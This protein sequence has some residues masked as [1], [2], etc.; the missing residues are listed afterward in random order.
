MT[1]TLWKSLCHV[2]LDDIWLVGWQ[3][4]EPPPPSGV[5]TYNGPLPPQVTTSASSAPPCSTLPAFPQVTAR[6]AATQEKLVKI[7][8]GVSTAP[9]THRDVKLT[10]EWYEANEAPPHVLHNEGLIQ[11][12]DEISGTTHEWREA[13]KHTNRKYIWWRQGMCCRWEGCSTVRLS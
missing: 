10:G 13:F 8:G 3:L 7:S 6:T 12:L 1:R 5:T 9:S 2:V 4:L 11:K